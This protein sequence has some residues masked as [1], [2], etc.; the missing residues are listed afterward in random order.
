MEKARPSLV[1]N[2]YVVI[3]KFSYRS[4]RKVGLRVDLREKIQLEAWCSMFVTCVKLIESF[5]LVIPKIE[6]TI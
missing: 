2:S 6:D 1:S 5:H 3:N 4:R